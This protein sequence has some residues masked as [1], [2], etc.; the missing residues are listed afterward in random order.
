MKQ[1]RRSRLEFTIIELLVVIAIISVLA[2]LIMPALGKAKAR[3]RY[4]RWLDHKRNLQIDEGVTALLAIDEGIGDEITNYGVYPN[5]YNTVPEAYT[6]TVSSPN[7]PNWVRGRWM[8]KWALEFDGM[9]DYVAM[10]T[11]HIV[12]P[13]VTI[14]TMAIAAWF[15]ADSF[16]NPNARIVSKASGA[17]ID[18]HWFMLSTAPS[19][20]E[21]RLSFRLKAGG[22]TTELVANSGGLEVDVWTLAIVT[23]DGS[24]M[25]IYKD[26]ELVGAA[27]K[28]GDI[29]IDADVDVRIGAN[30]DDTN[31]FDG[32][33]GEVV[34]FNRSFSEKDVEIYFK[35]SAK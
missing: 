9:D 3:A 24:V 25:Q 32:I 27:G 34:L 13:D 19:G 14:D 16:G 30:P 20:G 17:N 5:E 22:T 23:Y 15:K 11:S 7:G 8:A 12:P 6:G 21:T 4:A 10:G 35:Q 29:D 1:F 2:T 31:Y 26:D 33:I 28:V 18:D